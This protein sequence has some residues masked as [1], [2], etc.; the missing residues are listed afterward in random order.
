MRVTL[1]TKL[2]LAFAAVVVVP[3]GVTLWRTRETMNALFRADFEARVSATTDALAEEYARLERDLGGAIAGLGGAG[4]EAYNPLDRLLLD[5]A[6]S[7]RLDPELRKAFADYLPALMDTANLQLLT[8]LDSEGTV[9]AAGHNPGR[10][11]DVDAEGL[12]RARA[13]E[14]KA[15][16]A[17]ED[18]RRETRD[19]A[20]GLATRLT[21]QLARRVERYGLSV[22]VAAGRVIDR[23]LLER[24]GGGGGAVIRLEDPLGKEVA[25]TAPP[26]VTTK[27]WPSGTRELKNPDGRVAAR[28]VFA[29]D[30]ANLEASLRRATEAAS[31]VAIV[32]TAL[33]LALALLIAGRISRPIRELSRAAGDVARGKL[34]ATGLRASATDEVGDLVRAFDHMTRELDESRKDLRR[35]ERVAAWR[36]VAQRIAHE[37]KNPL[38]PIRTSVETLRRAR[39]KERPDFGEIFEESTST[40]LEE[41][42]RLRRIVDEFSRFARMPSPR[43]EPTDLEEVVRGAAALWAPSVP[44]VVLSIEIDGALRGAAAAGEAGRALPRV[45]ADREQVTQVLVNLLKN[46]GEATGGKGTVTLRLRSLAEARAVELSVS[47][48]GPGIPESAREQLFLPYFTTKAEGSGLGLAICH[49]IIGDHGGSIALGREGPGATFVITL[50]AV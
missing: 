27:G 18:L 14:G 36:E 38:S 34:R 5:W 1:R 45:R 23:D 37:I 28:L 13:Y 15:F 33:A 26:G 29:L 12:A 49:R 19:G 9:L 31:L 2:S 50:P 3:V 43:L 48:S 6:E 39:A 46:A 30:D 40:V 4:G 41:V 47:D 10:A 22:V 24:L 25:S 42:D 8:V 44:D 21:V 11:G 7:K 17:L 20:T 16:I 32:G 35:A